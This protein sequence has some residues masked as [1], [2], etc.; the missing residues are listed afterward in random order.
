MGI[1]CA[2]AN[3]T[4]SDPVIVAQAPPEIT[5]WGPY[6]FPWIERLAD[7]S[8]HVTVHLHADSATSY[9]LSNGHVISRDEGHSWQRVDAP[10]SPGGLLLP[11]GDRLLADCTKAFPVAGMALPPPM[12][13]RHSSYADFE[14]YGADALPEELTRAWPFLRLAR[15]T[16]EWKQEWATVTFN[17]AADVRTVTEQVLVVPHFEHNR[18]HVASDGSLIATL[19]T[20]PPRFLGRR[21]NIA[22]RGFLT[23]ILASNDFGRTWRE[24]G[25]IPYEPDFAADPHWDARDGFSEPQINEMPDGSLLAL[26]RSE[27]GNGG[28]D[29]APLYWARSEDHGVTWNRPAVFDDRGVWPQLLTLKSGV[30]LATYG[31]PGF[32]LRATRDPSGRQWDPRITLIDPGTDNPHTNTHTCAYSGLIALSDTRALLVYSEFKHPDAQGRTCKTLLSRFIDAQ[33]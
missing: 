6:Q 33:G 30:T 24:I 10:S 28:A 23:V 1:N 32:F 29:N 27:D 20:M 22:N 13:S 14:Y 18:I 25:A 7:G 16:S 8:L 4:L 17:K 5:G 21:R 3:Q 12:A 9:G 19:Y 26:L 11:N 15:G 31:R 2:P